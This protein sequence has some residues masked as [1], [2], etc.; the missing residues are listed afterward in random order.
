M[1]QQS[2]LTGNCGRRFP[3]EKV[4]TGT[5]GFHSS[6]KKNESFIN[7]GGKQPKERRFQEI[8]PCLVGKE[9]KGQPASS[10]SSCGAGY[11]PEAPA[12]VSL[13]AGAAPL[14]TDV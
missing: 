4:R 10:H 12:C 5:S 14:L 6:S 1:R 11:R 13:L 9:V 3:D 7:G 2:G 8:K